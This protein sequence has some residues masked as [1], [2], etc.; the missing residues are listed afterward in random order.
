MGTI[1][2]K[3]LLDHVRSVQFAVLL[4]ADLLLFAVNSLVF[5]QRYG[6]LNADYRPSPCQPGGAA[7]PA[8]WGRPSI[9][10]GP[11]P[12][13][14]QGREKDS[15]SGYY[16]GP[17]LTLFPNT[18]ELAISRYPNIPEL[19]W[20]FIIKIVLSLYVILLGFEAISGE[21]ERGTLRLVLS[22]PVGRVKLLTAKYAAII[23]SAAVPLLVG[24]LISLIVVGIF[25]PSVMGLQNLAHVAVFFIP[26]SGLPVPFLR[27]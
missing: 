16:L 18:A 21:R 3:E 20:A 1:I 5:V 12:V 24:L 19:D 9:I 23:A 13:I 14:G 4:G 10:A 15:P 2:R 22:N 27:S 8:R 6:R 25:L 7:S 26:R 11:L 17:K